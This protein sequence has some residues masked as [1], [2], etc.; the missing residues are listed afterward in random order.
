[1]L[2][3]NRGKE[4]ALCCNYSYN[5][6]RT[7]NDSIIWCCSESK[8][9]ATITT[10]N[11]LV[12]KVNGVKLEKEENILDQ[13]PISFWFQQ[14]TSSHNHNSLTKETI[15]ARKSLKNIKNRVLK[16]AIPLQ[17]TFQEEQS[18]FLKSNHGN[19]DLDEVSKVFP[20]FTSIQAGLYKKPLQSF[21]KLPD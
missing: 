16:E 13:L 10:S 8:C 20:Q 6:K 14:L 2:K 12:L 18:N 15:E 3:T 5:K 7:N 1:M 4:L 17:S 19:F 21:P 9:N 11:N